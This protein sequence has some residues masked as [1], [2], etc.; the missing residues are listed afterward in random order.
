MARGAIDRSLRHRIRSAR[1]VQDDPMGDVQLELEL[2]RHRGGA[3]KRVHCG[4]HEPHT[5][6]GSAELEQ[7]QSGTDGDRD[8]E[9]D[10]AV[11]RHRPGQ[12]GPHVV[13]MPPI[14]QSPLGRCGVTPGVL[15]FAH[16]LQDMLGV[17][18]SH[19]R[20][21]FRLGHVLR[22]VVAGGHEQAVVRTAAARVHRRHQRLRGQ[23]P[24]RF[25]DFRGRPRVAASD[26]ASGLQREAAGKHRDP[27]EHR[28][29]ARRQERVAPVERRFE[30][31]VSGTAVR[32][33]VLS[34]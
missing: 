9:F 16:Q 6:I 34:R 13:Q 10:V 8:A 25:E 28:T 33:P 21:F 19:G 26:R 4:A 31:S 30:R 29:L 2:R 27:S 7:Q 22:H 24:H 11:R 14:S 15:R 1:V 12:G 3:R 32:G 5:F 20:N 23:V 17:A 18:P